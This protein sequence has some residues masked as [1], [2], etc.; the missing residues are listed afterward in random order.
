MTKVT[1]LVGQGSRDFA[2]NLDDLFERWQLAHYPEDLQ[3]GNDVRKMDNVQ[4]SQYVGKAEVSHLRELKKELD[5]IHADVSNFIANDINAKAMDYKTKGLYYSAIRVKKK[6]GRYSN[7]IQ[8]EVSSRPK[9]TPKRNVGSIFIDLLWDE[10]IIP[11]EKFK[12]LMKR[13]RGI[14]ASQQRVHLTDSGLRVFDN[15][16]QSPAIGK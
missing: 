4:F 7:A 8:Q 3:S 5:I 9:D 2:H 14:Y 15:D 13:A 1:V 16:S 6:C 10:E 12:E 11:Q